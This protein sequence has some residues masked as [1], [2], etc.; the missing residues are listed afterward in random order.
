MNG[1]TEHPT[2]LAT[3]PRD[4]F[5]LLLFLVWLGFAA[6]LGIA[7]RQ[8]ADWWMEQ[9]VVVAGLLILVISYRWFQFSRVSYLLGFL[10]LCLHTIGAHYTYSQ[11]PYREWWQWIAGTE[12]FLTHGGGA[13]RNHF[14]RA[15]HFLY[16]LMLS[17]PWREVFYFAMPPRRDLWSQ[18]MVISFTMSTSLLYELL[19][20]AAAV[21]WGGEAGIA[22]LGTQGDPWDAHK[23]MFL[24]SLGSLFAVLYMKMRALLTGSDPARSWGESRR[25]SSPVPSQSS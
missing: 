22:F 23:D 9:I 17:R 11:V 10:F 6:I 24:A 13:T 8:R 1:S 4:R 12:G 16:G 21:V 14:D 2:P 25:Q 19:E 15:V 7:P 5:P 3:S 20:W 18:V